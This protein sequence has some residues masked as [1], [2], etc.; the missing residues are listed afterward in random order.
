MANIGRLMTRA[1]PLQSKISRDA[2]AFMQEVVSEF[3]CFLT[4]EANEQCL[5]GKRKIICGQ[6]LVTAMATLDL[7]DFVP[8]MTALLPK[9]QRSHR[10]QSNKPAVVPKAPPPL[11][12][13]ASMGERPVKVLRKV[14]AQRVV[15]LPVAQPAN[16]AQPLLAR[17]VVLGPN[18]IG[19]APSM[20]VLGSILPR[21]QPAVV[22]A[23]ADGRADGRGAMTY[24]P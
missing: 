1:T 17:A 20:T 22:A 9:C 3:I 21:T 12:A 16:A 19:M 23:A 13:S 15:P 24:M 18:R 14:V 6:D 4:S 11:A 2:K 5:I 7:D 8:S 10:S